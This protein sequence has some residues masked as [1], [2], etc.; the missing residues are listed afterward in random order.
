MPCTLTACASAR[1]IRTGALVVSLLYA[2]QRSRF[3]SESGISAM[4]AL[5]GES[6]LSLSAV[7]RPHTTI[8]ITIANE[9]KDMQLIPSQIG[10]SLGLILTFAGI[11]LV[12]FILWKLGKKL[13][14]IL[15]NSIFGIILMLLLDY[16]FNVGIPITIPTILSVAIFGLPGVGTLFILKLFGVSLAA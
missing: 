4:Q 9:Y 8:F 1:F 10:S 2:P 15:V 14:G 7:G 5:R 13:V 16:I 6:F 3:C 12:I 11:V